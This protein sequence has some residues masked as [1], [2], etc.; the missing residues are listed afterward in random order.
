MKEKLNELLIELKNLIKNYD[1]K[2]NDETLNGLCQAIIE[3]IDNLEIQCLSYEE[4]GFDIDLLPVILCDLIE[5]AVW[6]LEEKLDK[7]NLLMEFVKETRYD[8]FQELQ[9]VLVSIIKKCNQTSKDAYQQPSSVSLDVFP[10]L[11]KIEAEGQKCLKSNQ[12]ADSNRIYSQLF[13]II[14]NLKSM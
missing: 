7:I 5:H 13:H 1:K 2:T 11:Y 3:I 8:H 14:S 9:K 10:I 12:Y 4:I 6:C